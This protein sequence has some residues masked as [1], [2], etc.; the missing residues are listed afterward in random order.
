[1]TDRQ[2]ASGQAGRV[3][4]TPE[5]SGQ[6]PFYAKI[7]MADNPIDPGTPIN[8]A[9]LLQDMTASQYG[10]G[11]DAVPDD[12]FAKI[13]PQLP[14]IGDIKM[15]ARTS[16]GDKWL[17]CNGG[18]ISQSEYPE[19]YALLSEGGI[20]KPWKENKVWSAFDSP[21]QGTTSIVYG[22]GYY[23]MTCG[24]SEND[25]V[26]IYYSQS[27]AGPWTL[28]H[29][30]SGG[31]SSTCIRRVR[32]INSTFVAAGEYNNYPHIWYASNPAGAWTDITLSGSTAGGALDIIYDGSQYV[33]PVC[34]GI[35]NENYLYYSS[36]LNESWS[37]YTMQL[38]S[39]DELAGLAFG[40]GYYVAIINN[41]N[42]ADEIVYS[43]DV[44]GP[45]TTK[46][47]FQSGEDV[48]DIA[49]ADGYFVMLVSSPESIL[50]V[51]G[52]PGGDWQRKSQ[53]KVHSRS[54]RLNY[55]DGILYYSELNG[56]VIHY[57][58]SVTGNFSTVNVGDIDNCGG[59]AS[60][61]SSFA[62]IGYSNDDYVTVPYV[63]L[64]GLPNITVDDRVYAYI[65]ALDN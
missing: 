11:S 50:Y 10:L 37:V 28:A 29:E 57:G 52:N 12:V 14:Q 47:P 18:E 20:T 60:D 31:G 48:Y 55:I 59:I 46:N 40:N 24:N 64:G 58:E 32:Y 5:S 45:W 3:L 56:G 39:Y 65:K 54:E 19:L 1:M 41:S 8:K 30:I 62:S 36:A 13:E 44:T 33:I 9:T 35:D 6:M 61:G 34:E 26:R 21:P 25:T 16:L 51:Q 2:P 4:I 27:A 43:E 49:Y 15:T 42:G 38:G 63:L 22:S 7:E 17:L 23:V 53:N